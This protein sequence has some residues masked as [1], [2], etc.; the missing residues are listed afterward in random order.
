[1]STDARTDAA[2]ELAGPSGGGVDERLPAAKTATFAIQHLLIMYAGAVAVPLAFGAAMGLDQ[3]TIAM[4]VNADLLVCGIITIIQSLGVGRILGAR[5]PIIGGAT[6]IQLAPLVAIGQEYGLHA[7][8][9]CMLAGG[10]VGMLLAYPFS[11]V[12]R[13]FPPLVTGSVLVVVGCR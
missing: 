9:G 4:L 5:L 10:I 1:M 13:Y 12:I 11:L 7:V 2:N 3:A 8:W 6:F